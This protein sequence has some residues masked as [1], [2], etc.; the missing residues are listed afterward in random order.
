MSERRQRLADAVQRELV[1]QDSRPECEQSLRFSL[2][3]EMAATADQRVVVSHVFCVGRDGGAQMWQRL[4]ETPRREQR[5]PVRGM[6]HAAEAITRCQPQRLAGLGDCS[7][8]LAGP[9]LRPAQQPA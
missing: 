3:A 7:L 9:Q 1:A 4:F 2:H 5:Q 6:V 8:E